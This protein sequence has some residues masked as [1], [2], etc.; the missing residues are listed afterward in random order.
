MVN[1]DDV[2][3]V[4]INRKMEIKWWWM[5]SLSDLHQFTLE[6][7]FKDRSDAQEILDYLYKMEGIRP[8]D[9]KGNFDW[10]DNC[11]GVKL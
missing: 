11:K 8:E 10:L 4:N 9:I 3:T 6:P 2:L 5:C 1:M 7:T